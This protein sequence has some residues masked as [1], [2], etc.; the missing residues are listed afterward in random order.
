M[1]LFPTDICNKRNR[2]Y[3]LE[4]WVQVCLRTIQ[5]TLY[6]FMFLQLTEF[7]RVG[8][9]GPSVHARVARETESGTGTVQGLSMEG[10]TVMERGW[11]LRTVALMSV[12][13]SE[14]N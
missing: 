2:L 5:H 14:Y 9:T 4:Y 6:I 7:G 11:N 1:L 13:V 12:Q 10:K 8:A 3:C